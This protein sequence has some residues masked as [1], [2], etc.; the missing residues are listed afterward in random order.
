MPF[1]GDALPDSIENHG[2]AGTADYARAAEGTMSRLRKPKGVP[3]S[4][5]VAVPPFIPSAAAS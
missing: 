2:K 5:H 4:R 1:I 3:F